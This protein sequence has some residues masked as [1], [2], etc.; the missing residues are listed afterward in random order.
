M[1]IDFVS[2]EYASIMTDLL[3]SSL[4]CLKT[5]SLIH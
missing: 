2:Q 5:Y 3:T 1:K 4:F